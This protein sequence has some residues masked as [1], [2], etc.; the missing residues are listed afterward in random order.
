M[1][2]ESHK[3]DYIERWLDNVGFL[4]LAGPA[5]YNVHKYSS[6][7]ANALIRTILPSP[8]FANSRANYSYRGRASSAKPYPSSENP[9]KSLHESVHHCGEQAFPESCLP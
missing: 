3:H 4:E 1:S 2:A 5:K 6:S 9:Y 7:I 8:S